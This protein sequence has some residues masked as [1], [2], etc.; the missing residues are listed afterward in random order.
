V[1]LA[2]GYGVGSS[3][4]SRYDALVDDISEYH[5]VFA[6][7]PSHLVEVPASHSG[8]LQDWF[9][10]QIGRT[11]VVPDLSKSGFEFAGGRLFVVNGRPVAQLVYTK[12][13]T[14]PIGI[15]VTAL[16]ETPE[17]LRLTHRGDL[18]L[19]SWREGAYTYVMVGD[20]P[21][22]EMRDLAATA[23]ADLQG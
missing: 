7:D 1:G 6:R 16:A 21:D 4:P 19:A 22:R 8:E 23:A 14:L 2:V 20:L 18:N 9:R 15:C 10:E 11:L 3:P 5:G 12:P 17:R 13:G